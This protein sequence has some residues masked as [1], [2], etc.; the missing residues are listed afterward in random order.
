MKLTHLVLVRHG[1]Y[2]E[3]RL[4]TESGKDQIIDVTTRLKHEIDSSRIAV[5]SS[6]ELRA[7][8]SALIGIE[9]INGWL[10]QYDHKIHQIE[11]LPRAD[12]QRLTKIQECFENNSTVI[13][14]AHFEQIESFTSYLCMQLFQNN[15]ISYVSDDDNKYG[16]VLITNLKTFETKI[17]HPNE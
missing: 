14:F 12:K 1:Q 6:N 4:L 13:Y 15:S 8:Q 11:T 10:G 7:I 3:N 17:Y 16:T 5:F 9:T 2:D